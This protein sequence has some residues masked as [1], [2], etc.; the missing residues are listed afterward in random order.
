LRLTA[1][2]RRAVAYPDDE[3]ALAHTKLTLFLGD[4]YGSAIAAD[5]CSGAGGEGLFVRAD[6]GRHSATLL[7]GRG[8]GEL[9]VPVAYRDDGWTIAMDATDPRLLA[10]NLI[11]F[12]LSLRDESQSRYEFEDGGGTETSRGV[13]FDGMSMSQGAVGVQ[14]AAFISDA[15]AALIHRSVVIRCTPRSGRARVTCRRSMRTR[16]RGPEVAL[17]GSV[18]PHLR[19]GRDSTGDVGKLLYWTH[20]IEVQLKPHAC[21]SRAPAHRSACVLARHWRTRSSL[22]RL[23]AGRLVRGF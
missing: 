20:D 1:R 18:V 15:M 22:R 12:E 17:H 5:N 6:L 13:L 3:P 9:V 10:R 21:A 16:R 2:V 19:R 7:F 8:D 23:F 4:A 11:C 14:A